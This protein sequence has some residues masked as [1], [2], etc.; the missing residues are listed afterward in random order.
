LGELVDLDDVARVLEA[1]GVASF[2]KSFH[3]LLGVLERRAA[4]L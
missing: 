3:E 1:E 2:E 4:A